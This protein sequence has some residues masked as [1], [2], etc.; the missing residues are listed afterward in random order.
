MA[1]N[2]I[3]SDY[4]DAGQDAEDKKSYYRDIEIIA[5]LFG[6]L[7]QLISATH[8]RKLDYAPSRHL[9][10]LVDLHPDKLIR[11]IYSGKTF[12]AEE[13]ILLDEQV[14]I[15]RQQELVKLQQQESTMSEERFFEVLNDLEAALPYN[16][17]HVVPQSWFHKDNPMRGRPASSFCM[18][19]PLQ[20]HARQSTLPRF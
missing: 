20:F 3:S 5:P 10:P 8:H 2:T 15:A 16:C 1:E 17:E 11:S 12:T 9:Y 14:D 19:G 6:E 4:F 13:L 7:N 18:R